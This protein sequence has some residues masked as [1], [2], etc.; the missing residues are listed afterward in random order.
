[1]ESLE[2]L[3][4]GVFCLGGPCMSSRGSKLRPW[5]AEG[6]GLPPSHHFL[7]APS[8]FLPNILFTSL[9]P[10]QIPHTLLTQTGVRGKLKNVLCWGIWGS[11]LPTSPSLGL[12]ASVCLSFFWD[13]VE[14]ACLSSPLAPLTSYTCWLS[15]PESLLAPSR[16]PK[17][18][19]VLL[20]LPCPYIGSR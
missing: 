1:M 15:C 18:H 19:S 8:A 9:D 20:P 2:T 17:P 13:V 5:V 4:G 12:S 6:P 10:S 14:T 16:L 11:L 3:P 7:P